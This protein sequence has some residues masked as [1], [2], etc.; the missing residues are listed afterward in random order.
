MAP[1]GMLR[2]AVAE[3]DGEPVSAFSGWR[4]GTP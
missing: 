1:A 2:M 4:T 3:V